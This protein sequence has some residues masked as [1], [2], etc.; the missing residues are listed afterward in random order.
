MKN[1]VLTAA[2][3]LGLAAASMGQTLPAYLPTDGLVG[4][5]PFNGNANDESG[6]GN[7]GIASNVIY[8]TDRFGNSNSTVQIEGQANRIVTVSNPTNLNSNIKTFSAWIKFP[9]ALS[10]GLWYNE[11][12]LAEPLPNSG[13]AC[14]LQILGNNPNYISANS[15]YKFAYSACSA[16]YPPQLNTNSWE[17]VVCIADMNDMYIKYALRG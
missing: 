12:I 7:D 2:A 5:W 3:L 17:H 16:P 11:I 14:Y 1:L 15:I 9:T 10:S 6:N 4:W 13:N 8:G